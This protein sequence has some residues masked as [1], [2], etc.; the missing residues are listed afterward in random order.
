MHELREVVDTPMRKL[1]QSLTP[2]HS[3]L[4]VWELLSVP[5]HPAPSIKE[6][7]SWRRHCVIHGEKA[8]DAECWNSWPIIGIL[9][10]DLDV[11]ISSLERIAL[12]SIMQHSRLSL[13]DTYLMQNGTKASA[14]HLFS[15][16]WLHNE[17]RAAYWSTPQAQGI[18]SISLC[19]D[20]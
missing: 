17:R 14:T 5:C 2:S 16:S 11:A 19:K 4:S 13:I 9:R 10:Q 1:L 20:E 15:S 18:E 3:S 6:L 8:A 12:I 7:L